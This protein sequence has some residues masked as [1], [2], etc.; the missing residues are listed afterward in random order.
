MYDLLALPLRLDLSSLRLDLFSLR[1]ILQALGVS[2]ASF[3][4]YAL[5]RHLRRP[6]T[7]R[8]AGPRSTSLLFGVSRTLFGPE[9]DQGEVAERWAAEYGSVY[10]IPTPLGSTRVVVTDPKAILHFYSR[11]TYGYVQS[12]F[13]KIAIENIVSLLICV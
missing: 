6:R 10:T 4:A 9:A 5:L 7:T 11:E 3:V 12:A 1:P 8:L 13:A 2:V